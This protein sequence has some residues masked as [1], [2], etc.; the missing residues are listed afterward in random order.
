MHFLLT[1]P[2][3]VLTFLLF[4][5]SDS[6]FRGMMASAQSRRKLAQGPGRKQKKKRTKDTEQSLS[7]ARTRR[8]Y[9]AKSR[10]RQL[11]P[12]ADKPRVT[13][14]RPKSAS[15]RAQSNLS[16]QI[17]PG[18]NVNGAP[19]HDVHNGGS[20]SY[21]KAGETARADH[22]IPLADLS[23]NATAMRRSLPSNAFRRLPSSQVKINGKPSPYMQHHRRRRMN[24]PNSAP[25]HRPKSTMLPTMVR[26]QRGPT[27]KHSFTLIHHSNILSGEQ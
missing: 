25:M 11:M 19:V 9:S 22:R 10:R 24:R 14:R 7:N 1:S 17:Y 3:H 15:M 8:P 21:Y 26:Q 2:I 27:N 13:N 16:R 12:L 18:L 4:Q 6:V 23:G 20:K 5:Q